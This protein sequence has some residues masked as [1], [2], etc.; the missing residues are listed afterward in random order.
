VII[1]SV[2]LKTFLRSLGEP[3]I[4]NQLYTEL[5][6]ING[7]LTIYAYFISYLYLIAV[8]KSNQLNAIRALL[9]KL[10]PEN[11]LLMKRIIQLLAQVAKHSEENLMN[12]NNLSVIFGPNLTWPTDQQVSMIIFIMILIIL[13][14]LGTD[15]AIKLFKPILLHDNSPH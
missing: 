13:Y 5:T 12:A 4:T 11:Y 15:V 10:P 3:L 7:K 14:F 2:L 1:A 6:Q 8:E 9:Q